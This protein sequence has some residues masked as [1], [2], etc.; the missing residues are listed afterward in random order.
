MS[1]KSFNGYLTFF[2]ETG[3]EGGY[4][5]FQEEGK[6][7]YDGLHI[8]KDGD[9]ITVFDE[10][11]RKEIWGGEIRLSPRSDIDENVFGFRVHSRQI[12]VDM[13][14]WARMFFCE[15]PAVLA[16]VSE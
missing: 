8:L 13:D 11:S 5:A 1:T 4:W 14:E 15:Y 2:T 7:G 3:T 12:G 10:T 6:D 9:R 16:T